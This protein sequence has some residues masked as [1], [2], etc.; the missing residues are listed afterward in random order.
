MNFVLRQNMIDD[1]EKERLTAV[2][3]FTHFFCL[4]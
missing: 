3:S 4:L 1:E 2:T